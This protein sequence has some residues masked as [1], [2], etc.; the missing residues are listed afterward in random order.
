LRTT[1]KRLIDGSLM[2]DLDLVSTHHGQQNR[3][4]PQTRQ[5]VE[6]GFLF[7]DWFAIPQITARAEGV[8]EEVT[9]S[10]AARAVKSIPSYVE[11][12]S[13]FIALV[14]FVPD[15]DRQ[16]WCS[17]TTWLAR[18]WCRAQL[19]LHML[20]S[21]PDTSVILVTS[22]TEAKF[23]FPL[24]WL[25]NT[26]D[27][28]DF[29][30]EED[31]EVVVQLGE[32][33][34]E[35]RICELRDSGPLKVF[36]FYLARRSRMLGQN[37]SEWGV[38]E[39]LNAFQFTSLEEAATDQSSMNGLMCAVFSSDSGMIRE[40]VGSR[41]DVNWRSHGLGKAGYFD[42]QTVLICAAKSH[43]PARV[44]ATLIELHADV[45]AT[46]SNGSTVVPM[47]RSPE[48]LEV[49]IQARA[50][51]HK[52]THPVGNTPL[53]GACG[54]ANSETIAALLQAKCN[55]NPPV[56]GHGLSPLHSAI[57]FSRGNRSALRNV[58]L[59]LE[60]RANV[61][62]IATPTGAFNWGCQ[63][64]RV[65]EAVLGTSRCSFHTRC[66]AI[67]PSISPLG[68]A[69]FI[70][71]PDLVQLLL[72]FGAN[73]SVPNARGDFPEDLATVNGHLHLLP[74]LRTFHV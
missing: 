61:N 53:G 72:D 48:Q 28:G 15:R 66:F 7:F 60:H 11:V 64:A 40:L 19:W 52:L 42:G 24:D 30:V 29:T 14:P 56:F 20:S 26:I 43:Q 36:R 8:N 34:L 49:V 3:F 71:D 27:S 62:A 47:V 16:E 13:L 57:F 65:Y 55:P 73:S 33:A 6:T 67:L 2:I 12:A 23:M 74:I 25:E 37:R 35:S 21:K 39:F 46:I 1:L 17:Y 4:T 44:L 70:G 5:Q 9:K 69:S 18:G 31:R 10:D 68:I 51:L 38:Q 63:V 45:H 54:M 22:V 50:D 32:K 58:Q 41:A 59:L